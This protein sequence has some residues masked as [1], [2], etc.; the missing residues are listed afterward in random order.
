M[1]R[2]ILLSL[3]TNDNDYQ[4]EQA[5]VA[6]Q[7]ATRLGIAL[8]IVY[9]ENDAI[10]QSQQLLEVIQGPV[11]DRPDAII[12][13]PVGTGLAQ[14]AGAAARAGI[15][16]AVI[17][18]EV[19]YIS[20]L[21]AKYSVP[22]LSVG[23]DHRDIGRIQGR[24]L[25]AL[26]PS[27]GVVLYIQG[28]SY[29]SV[30]AARTAG[31]MQAKPNNVQLRSLKAD[32]TEEGACR[33]ISSWLRLSTSR[34]AGVVAVAAQN[35]FMARGARKAFE[36]ETTGND[37]HYWMSLP[38][39]GCD[40]LPQTGAAWVRSGLLMATVVAPPNSGQAMEMMLKA[41]ETGFQPPE[42]TVV[43]S[44]AYPAEQE[45]AKSARLQRAGAKAGF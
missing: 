5:A 21:R 38:F 17:N 30:S 6:E 22:I 35:D 2:R 31:M 11:D 43:P 4:Q 42:H 29:S 44:H 14:V 32:W 23:S 26:L 40:G 27:G 39:L 15:G 16:W 36:Q 9:A 8:S 25:G 37:L 12:V 7:T 13:E 24:Q 28:P 18:R 33:A 10:T 41:L 1:K 3:I 34:E 20:A 19:D 45:L